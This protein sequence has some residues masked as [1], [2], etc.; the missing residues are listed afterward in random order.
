MWWEKYTMRVGGVAPIAMQWVVCY[1]NVIEEQHRMFLF[2]LFQVSGSNLVPFWKRSAR[3]PPVG[4]HRMLRFPQTVQRHANLVNWSLLNV[5]WGDGECE[6]VNRVHTVINS[7]RVRDA[8]CLS[9]PYGSWEGGTGY[10]SPHWPKSLI[11][12]TPGALWALKGC[13]QSFT[14]AYPNCSSVK[15]QKTNCSLLREIKETV[16]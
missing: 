2:F 7:R 9:A 12:S 14:W 6:C 16:P 5:H 13:Q 11:C 4:F 8:P 3:S 10:S 15:D 1:T